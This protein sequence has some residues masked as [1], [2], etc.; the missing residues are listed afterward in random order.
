MGASPV[1]NAMPNAMIAK[2]AKNPPP[3]LT[4]DEKERWLFLNN[5]DAHDWMVKGQYLTP[6]PNA[7]SDYDRGHDAGYEEGHAEGYE[8]GHAEAQA[9]AA[10]K[11]TR[12]EAPAVALEIHKITDELRSFETCFGIECIKN[13]PARASVQLHLR[14]TRTILRELADEI[15]AAHILP[16]AS[17]PAPTFANTSKP[18]ALRAAKKKTPQHEGDSQ[19]NL[20]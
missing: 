18:R 13:R 7:E 4:I 14:K 16:Y 11:P 17:E 5:H 6:T 1:K 9:N 15:N 20:L 8:E 10:R 2:P 3:Y 19:P 12:I